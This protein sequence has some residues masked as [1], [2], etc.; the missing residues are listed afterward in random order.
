MRAAIGEIE[1]YR[2]IEIETLEPLLV[3]GNVVA[4]ISHLLAEL[5]DNLHGLPVAVEFRHASWAVDPVFAEFERR[6]ITLVTVD[7]PSSAPETVPSA[8]AIRAR[9]TRGSRPSASTRSARSATPTSVPTVSKRSISTKTTMI[10]AKPMRSAPGMS[11][12][13]AVRPSAEK[14]GIDT[15]PVNRVCP[16]SSAVTADA[17]MPSSSAPGTRLKTVLIRVYVAYMAA[18]QTLY[19]KY[20]QAL[21]PWMTL[22]GY[23]NSMRELGGMRRVV[24]DAHHMN[25][26]YAIESTPT[27]TGTLADHR[28]SLPPA[29]VEEFGRALAAALFVGVRG[30]VDDELESLGDTEALLRAGGWTLLT[31]VCLMLFSLVHNPCSTTIYTIWK[32]TRSAKWTALSA[33]LPLVMGF[34]IVFTTATIARL[35]GWA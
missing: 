9:P 33:L 6:R 3:R 29:R 2:R 17:I 1:D 30:P 23:F 28:F 19:E 12:W 32:E 14:S 5:L 27:N 34:G 16:Q 8:S 21:D 31:A 35:F 7:V 4:D 20:G 24:D 18:A 22:V 11:S 25:R 15:T 13:K 10:V 26:L